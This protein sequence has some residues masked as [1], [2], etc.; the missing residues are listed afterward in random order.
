M[1]EAAIPFPEFVITWI[2]ESGMQQQKDVCDDEHEMV[3]RMCEKRK[4]PCA[5]YKKVWEK[6]PGMKADEHL[7]NFTS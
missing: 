2:D 1:A 7:M 5:M 6:H 3:Q 4:Y